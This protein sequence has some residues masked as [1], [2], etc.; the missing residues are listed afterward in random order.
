[1]RSFSY[2]LDA[3]LMRSFS[4]TPHCNFNEEIYTHLAPLMRS[5]SYSLDASFSEDFLLHSS[6]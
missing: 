5:F 4:C 6:C 1:M 2:S 3:T